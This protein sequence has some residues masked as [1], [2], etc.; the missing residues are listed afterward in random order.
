LTLTLP[1]VFLGFSAAPPGA[2]QEQEPTVAIAAGAWAGVLETSLGLS[3][4]VVLAL[5]DS[6]AAD[7]SVGRAVYA[8]PGTT[9]RYTLWLDEAA[10]PSVLELR[11]ELYD[12]NTRC[13][14]RSRLVLREAGRAR[15]AADWFWLDGT[16]WMKARL[17]K[18]GS[19]YY[20]TLDGFRG[21]QANLSERIRFDGLGAGEHTVELHGV[22]GECEVIGANP[23]VIVTEQGGTLET[24]FAVRCPD[25]PQ[26]S[27]A[28]SESE[29]PP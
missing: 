28:E 14:Q 23:R 29:P 8:T 17:D 22:P 15:L 1:G 16:H 7:G 20:V 19:G 26:V 12:D 2:G 25:D 9:C 5:W 3:Q 10:G 21:Q 13:V 4:T 6:P 11:Q 24:S 27:A 18:P